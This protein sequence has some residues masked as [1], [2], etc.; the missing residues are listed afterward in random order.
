MSTQPQVTVDQVRALMKQFGLR[1]PNE[2]DQRNGKFVEKLL[3]DPE[4][5]AKARAKAK[6]AFP[7]IELPEDKLGPLIAPLKADND[8]LRAQLKELADWRK[9]REE[10]E[11]K[12][13]NFQA[14]QASI[15][16][17]VKKFNLT[18]D[19]MKA[20]MAR[21]LEQKNPDAEAAAALVTHNAPKPAASPRFVTPKANFYGSA[22]YDESRK[23]LHTR[24]DDFLDAEI[25]E[26]MNNPE[27]YIA[28]AA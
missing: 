2:V 20:M 17:A 22:E 27:A 8:A 23:L 3:S 16:A 14:T 6:E 28:S 15:E 19:G 21:M 1:E 25:T 26:A 4:L 24:P 7:D 5:G 13:E 18:E 9:A 10:E 12:K 11:A